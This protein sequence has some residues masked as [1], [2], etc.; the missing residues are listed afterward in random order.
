VQT[1][2]E[3][4]PDASIICALGSMDATREG[5][6]WPRYIEQAVKILNDKK[7]YTYFFPYK[8]TDGHPRVSDQKNMADQLIQFI[9]THIQLPQLK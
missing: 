4:Y 5:S 8:G 7:M 3:K 1:I 9:D 6:A 2:R